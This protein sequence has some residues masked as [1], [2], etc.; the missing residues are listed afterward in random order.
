MNYLNISL[1]CFALIH[2][3]HN[4]ILFDQQTHLHAAIGAARE[5]TP[6]GIHIHLTDPLPSVL[7]EA[8][9]GVLVR[10]RVDQHELV[11]IPDL[12][13]NIVYIVYKIW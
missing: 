13:A 6:E 1:C 4:I 11:H 7:E 8:V 12:Q 9:L 10:E 3:L 5:E 2:G